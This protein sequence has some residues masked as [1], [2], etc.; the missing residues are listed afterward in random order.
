MGGG[1]C[2]N[3]TLLRENAQSQNQNLP[4]F[5]AKSR[6]KIA[7]SMYIH[8]QSSNHCPSGGRWFSPTVNGGKIPKYFWFFTNLGRPCHC[9][10]KSDTAKP[11]SRS[12]GGKNSFKTLTVSCL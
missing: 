9:T 4:N 2:Q 5:D 7:E 12:K 6:G 10:G 8:V 11:E 1:G 3:A